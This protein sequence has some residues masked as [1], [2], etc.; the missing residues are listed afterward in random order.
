MFFWYQIMEMQ[1]DGQFVSYN[2]WD[3]RMSPEHEG[4]SG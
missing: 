4:T 3:V 2:G 1:H